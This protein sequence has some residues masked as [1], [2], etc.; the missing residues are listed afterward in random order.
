MI[1][2]WVVEISLLP[3]DLMW[4]NPDVCE[5]KLIIKKLNQL[6]LDSLKLAL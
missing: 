4:N 6:Q 1:C 3:S 2:D 5:V